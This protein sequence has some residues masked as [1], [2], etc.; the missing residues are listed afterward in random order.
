MGYSAM[1]YSRVPAAESKR[2][3]LKAEGL[4]LHVRPLL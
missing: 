4:A 3:G 1:L 2:V